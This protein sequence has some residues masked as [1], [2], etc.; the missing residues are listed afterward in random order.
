MQ[1]QS[2]KV[3]ENSEAPGSS[4]ALSKESRWEG[5]SPGDV[6]PSALHLSRQNTRVTS[7]GKT[8]AKLLLQCSVTQLLGARPSLSNCSSLKSELLK[9]KKKDKMK[10]TSES[11]DSTG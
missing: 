8:F 5:T 2:E 1:R 7:L 10:R 4:S 9:K 3:L 6:Q 11:W